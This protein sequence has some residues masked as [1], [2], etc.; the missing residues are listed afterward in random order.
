MEIQIKKLKL[1]QLEQNTGQIEGLPSNP[2][3][4]TQTDI[5]C[6]AQS[7]VDTPELFE[8]RPIVVYPL[9]KRYV[10]LAGN[11]RYSASKQI[12][13]SSVPCAI[14]PK[15]WD[16]RKLGEIVLKDNGI[17]GEWDYMAL[18]N[19][20]DDIDLESLGIKTFQAQDYS[21][22]NTELDP[23][24]LKDSIILKLKFHEPDATRVKFALGDNPKDKL[25][26]ALNYDKRNN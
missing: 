26:K 9:D 1:S 20:W 18:L 24:S 11:L 14:V 7:L 25:L 10:I 2:R 13:L 17:F 8:A 22:K 19:E 15:E 4:W 3:Q 21:D 6:L 23:S 5:D 16:V 12:E